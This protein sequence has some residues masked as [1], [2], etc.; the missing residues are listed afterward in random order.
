MSFDAIRWALGQPIKK[1]SAKFVLVAMA[2]CVNAEV[3]GH[4]TCWPSYRHLA[5]RTGQDPKTVE[6]AVKWLR[7]EGYIL[8]TGERQGRTGGVVVY[9]LN[10]TKNGVA[11]PSPEPRQLPDAS[12]GSTPENGGTST[13]SNPTFGVTTR[14]ESDPVFPASDPVFPDKRPQFSLEATPKT[15]Y[16]ISKG[17]RK[18]TSKESGKAAPTTSIPDVP[19]DLVSDWQAVRKDKRAGPLTATVI[20]GLTREARKAGVTVAEAVRACCEFGWQG[21]NAG[22]YAQRVAKGRASATRHTGFDQTLYE[23]APDGSIPIPP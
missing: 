17:T 14:G 20:A 4:W 8:D 7:D 9:R 18:G 6:T 3:G 16:G 11:L 15:G 2:D 19:D 21:F 5:A 10:T 13:T 22:W 23:G 1:S 12:A